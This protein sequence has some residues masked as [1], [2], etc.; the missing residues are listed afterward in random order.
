MALSAAGSTSA[1]LHSSPLKHGVSVFASKRRFSPAL[2]KEPAESLGTT[3]H[4]ATESSAA[5]S[6]DDVCATTS[7]F[8]SDALPTVPSGS[9]ADR[10]SLTRRI[11][12]RVNVNSRGSMYGPDGG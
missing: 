6:L 2:S 3:R 11:G 1:N 4:H 8:A 12:P 7:S 5:V 9:V 10:N